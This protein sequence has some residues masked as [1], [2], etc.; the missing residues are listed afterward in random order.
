[1]H[2]FDS[3]HKSSHMIA[4]RLRVDSSF[5]PGFLVTFIHQH[6]M[7]HKKSV[8]PCFLSKLTLPQHY[9]LRYTFWLKDDFTNSSLRHS[10]P[11]TAVKVW[12]CL[13]MA[14]SGTMHGQCSGEPARLRT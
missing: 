14:G 5:G 2:G 6:L 12:I 8:N 3:S 7:K 4:I 1:M 10:Y 11:F 13:N 9:I